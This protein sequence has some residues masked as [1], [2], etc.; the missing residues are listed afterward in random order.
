[1][2]AILLTLALAADPVPPKHEEHCNSPPVT[3]SHAPQSSVA[4]ISVTWL[5]DPIDAKPSDCKYIEGAADDDALTGTCSL[6]A[7]MH[8]DTRKQELRGA[9]PHVGGTVP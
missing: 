4:T 3:P 7:A 1:M 9:W 6:R 8:L 2:L 5:E